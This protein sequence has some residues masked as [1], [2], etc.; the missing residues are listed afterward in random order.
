[1]NIAA[2]L[3][4]CTRAANSAVSREVN[5]SPEKIA[6]KMPMH[7]YC[8]GFFVNIGLDGPRGGG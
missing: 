4:G 8:T 7:A 3:I 1:L 5:I 6:T 2:E